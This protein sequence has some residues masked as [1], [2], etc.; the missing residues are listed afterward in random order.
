MMYIVAKYL[1]GIFIM[2]SIASDTI[3]MVPPDGFKHNEQT[4]ASNVFQNNIDDVDPAHTAMREFDNMV[5]ALRAH[6]I[7]VLLLKQDDSL[8]D[9]VF[10]N[11]WFSTHVDKNGMT[12]IIIYPMLTP[13]RRAEVNVLKLKEVLQAANIKVNQLIDLREESGKILEGTGSLIFDRNNRIV[14]AALSERTDKDLVQELAIMMDYHAVIFHAVDKRGFPIY[15][16]NVLMGLADDFAVICLECITDKTE[17]EMV[18][19]S[20]RKTS[21]TIVDISQD[22]LQEMCGN[23]LAVRNQK[24]DQFLVMSERA[25]KHFTAEQI[26][27]IQKHNKIIAVN[28][29]IIEKIGGGSA[30]C[31]MAEIYHQ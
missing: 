28:I 21:K 6:G 18:A 20:L 24:G 25:Q 22:Q 29:D 14:Y 1:F 19:E 3:V 16:T 8:P 5:A 2:N 12:D 27:E 17:R 13:N 15:H 11:N 9:A 10:P 30:R 23:V 26:A 7:N 31:M 4:A